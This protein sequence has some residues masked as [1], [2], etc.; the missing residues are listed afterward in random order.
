MATSS[1]TRNTLWILLILITTGIIVALGLRFM[2]NEATYRMSYVVHKGELVV[3][4][5]IVADARRVYRH[6]ETTKY[7][8]RF[9]LLHPYKLAA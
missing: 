8:R 2:K 6:P 1:R 7:D 3:S 5:D 9:V 4:W